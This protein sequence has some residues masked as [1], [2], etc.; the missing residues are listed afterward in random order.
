MNSKKKLSI[1]ILGTA[2]LICASTVHS[3]NWL[4]LQG[5]EPDGQSN[6]ANVWGFIQPEYQSTSGTP[7]KAGPWK[8]NNAVFNQIGPDLKTNKTFSI[9]RARIGVR[10]TGFP[11]DNKVNYFF[12]AEFGNNGITRPAGGTGSAKVT[13]A[14]VTLSHIPGARIRVGQFKT[15]GA[16]EG[17]QAIHVFDY[18]NFTGVTNGLLLERFFD[19]DGSDTSTSGKPPIGTGIDNPNTPNGPVSAFRDIGIQVFDIFKVGEWE[20]SYAIMYGNGNGITRADNDDNK[21]TYLYLSTE[22]VFGGK[23]GR[24]QGWKMFVWNQDGKRTLIGTD[25]N[26]KGEYDRTRRGLGTTFRKG[27]YRAAF[28]YI[29]ADGMIVNGTDGAAVPGTPFTDGAGN[30]TT[31]SVNVETK[32]E[33]DGWYGHFGYMVLPK[34][35]L[36]LRYDIF[37]RMTN[38]A[39][40]ERKLE[41]VTLGA[42]YFFNQ[43]S[44]VI[45]NYEFRDAEAPGLAS[46]AGPNLIADGL[47]DRLSAQLLIIF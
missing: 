16:D 37:N 22:W 27:K 17:L 18:V 15:P 45:L 41:T 33:A 23:G 36:D 4:A 10:G 3:A 12:L 32:G 38:D 11:L 39:K 5:T 20:H 30:T 6:R 28:E 47:D 46:S 8:G 14:S 43:K 24:R 34:L 25:A 42:Q 19:G 31:A 35:E 40:L 13:D 44:R 29:T 9:R 7:I 1:K 26:G 2:L 21:E